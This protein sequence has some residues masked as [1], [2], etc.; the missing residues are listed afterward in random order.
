MNKQP[1][2]WELDLIFLT[3]KLLETYGGI[4]RRIDK[5]EDVT[6]RGKYPSPLDKAMNDIHDLFEKELKE[7]LNDE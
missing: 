1:E 2:K 3:N 7:Y 4:V 5:G 6:W